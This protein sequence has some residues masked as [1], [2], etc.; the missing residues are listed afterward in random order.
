MSSYHETPPYRTYLYSEDHQTISKLA[1]EDEP[2][3]SDL[4]KLSALISTVQDPFMVDEYGNSPLHF[5]VNLGHFDAVR[6]LLRR[7]HPLL[8]KNLDG[9][10][11]L[12]LAVLR[13]SDLRIPDE[14][15]DEGTHVELAVQ[16]LS[17]E[18]SY[19]DSDLRNMH[20]DTPLH[21]ACLYKHHRATQ[22]LIQQYHHPIDIPNF[23]GDIP[24]HY[25]AYSDSETIVALLL[26]C[27]ANALIQ[28]S[29]GEVPLDRIYSQYSSVA[30]LLQN[31]SMKA[32]TLFQLLAPMLD[33]VNN[34]LMPP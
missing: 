7:G 12:H 24:L 32:R 13:R 17:V 14:E 10:L 31:A 5:A 4:T 18:A 8:L 27:G 33:H 22:A 6:V 11:P 28:N 15:V 9:N 21:Y 29:R 26:E 30:V 25:A 19:R 2:S 16:L 23:L 20:G 34:F 1:A 3:I